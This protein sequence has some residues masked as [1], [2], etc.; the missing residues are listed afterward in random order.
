MGK[1]L[2]DHTS[3]LTPSCIF[4]DMCEDIDESKKRWQSA[5][6]S[7][8][9]A[10]VTIH[11]HH[12]DLGG[13]PIIGVDDLRSQIAELAACFYGYPADQ[14]QIFGVTGT[15]GKTTV[16]YAL[17]Q[18][19]HKLGTKS[20]FIGTFGHTTTFEQNNCD[21]FSPTITNTPSCIELQ[22]IL[23]SFRQKAVSVVCMEMSSHG[24]VQG[25]IDYIPIDIAA[26]TNLSRDHLDF[27]KTMFNYGQA[28]KRLFTHYPVAQ[29]I[30]SVNDSL[31]SEIF[32]QFHTSKIAV[33]NSDDSDLTYK[34]VQSNIA[35]L[36]FTIK[37]D[38]KVYTVQSQLIGS[39]NAENLA[40]VWVSLVSMNFPPDQ[41]T[42]VLSEIEPIPGRMQVC[43]QVPLRP[44]VVVD[45][46]HTPVSLEKALIV[47][48][49]FTNKKV[50]CLFGCGGDR[51][52]GKRPLM[53][54]IA[55]RIA[56]R[57]IITQDNSRSEDPDMIASDILNGMICPWAVEMEMDRVDA[58]MRAI[59]EAQPGDIVLIAGRGHETTLQIAGE[60]IPCDDHSIACQALGVA[61][62]D[63]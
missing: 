54:Q 13:M 14:M 59:N 2:V 62:V 41:V 57:V 7:G 33:S 18:C 42:A 45:Y 53:G 34:I 47:L 27:H 43:P 61:S 16:A 5:L 32:D 37:Y 58:I 35:G 52:R 3:H 11:K 17:A 8:A 6:K 28:K 21:N 39:F 48:R 46:A 50:W 63:A 38:D 15:N 30:V 25:R 60:S 36:K 19:L 24:I 26:Y 31:G 1:Q 55:E 29:A 22:R 20:A 10:V 56:D 4:V 44:T 12:D 49:K 9:I 40:M 23:A 51:D